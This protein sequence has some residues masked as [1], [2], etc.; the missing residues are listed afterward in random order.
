MQ[1]GM[2]ATYDADSVNFHGPML[3]LGD[4]Q[5]QP[6]LTQCPYRFRTKDQG[7]NN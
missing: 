4:L 5:E 7:V 3:D 1:H 2:V 6:S